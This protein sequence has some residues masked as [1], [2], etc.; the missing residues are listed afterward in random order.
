MRLGVDEVQ[1]L[2][3]H[4]S[5]EELAPASNRSGDDAQLDLIDQAFFQQRARPG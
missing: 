3:L 1:M 4:L 2:E 5:F